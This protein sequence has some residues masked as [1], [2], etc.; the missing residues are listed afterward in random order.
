MKEKES[1]KNG[2]IVEVSNTF[3]DK[4]NEE[5]DGTSTFIEKEEPT[6]TF[7]KKEDTE[8]E[9]EVENMTATFIKKEDTKEEEGEEY[10]TNTFIQKDDNDND[11]GTNTFIQKGDEDYGTSTFIQKEDDDR[12]STFIQKEEDEEDGTGTFVKKDEKEESKKIPAFHKIFKFDEEQ[13][14]ED[15]EEE[16]NMGKTYMFDPKKSTDKLVFTEELTKM[17]ESITKNSIDMKIEKSIQ[18]NQ[19][20]NLSSVFKNTSVKEEFCF[21]CEEKIRPGEIILN[22]NNQMFHTS[23]YKCVV[24]STVYDDNSFFLV[25]NLPFCSYHH[26]LLFSPTCYKVFYFFIFFL[27]FFI[28]FIF[29]IFIIFIFFIFLFLLIFYFKNF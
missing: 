23:C 15:P 11:D 4:S 16:K 1:S 21:F 22:V 29:F 28:F 10:G 12:T 2:T 8:E 24:C 7:I 5:E 20:K 18:L 17:K 14:E 26:H 25:Q 27:F 9:E 19:N 6:A 13:D 3:I